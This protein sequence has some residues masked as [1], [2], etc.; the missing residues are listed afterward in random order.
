MPTAPSNPLTNPSTGIQTHGNGR[1]LPL[2]DSGGSLPDYWAAFIA[3]TALFIFSDMGPNAARVAAALGLSI[4]MVVL[5]NWILTL[6]QNGQR[7]FGNKS[8]WE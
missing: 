2:K 6:K 1:P 5:F 3:Y 7:P 8:F 4:G